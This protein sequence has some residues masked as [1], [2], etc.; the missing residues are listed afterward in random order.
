MDYIINIHSYDGITTIF[1]GLNVNN[2]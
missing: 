2:C 1:N